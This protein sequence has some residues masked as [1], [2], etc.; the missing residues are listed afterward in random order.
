MV[1]LL[2]LVIMCA[3]TT[4]RITSI[5]HGEQMFDWGRRRLGV[6]QT[7]DDWDMWLYPAGI[8]GEVWSCFWCLSL[9]VAAIVAIVAVALG[10][11]N[12][13]EWL[14]LWLA[15]A[16]GAIMVDRWTLRGK[17]RS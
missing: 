2:A 5:L 14:L 1:D 9:L 16:A 10:F 8:I 13:R 6:D 11:A 15:S 3:L 12:I 4:W 7:S 17:A